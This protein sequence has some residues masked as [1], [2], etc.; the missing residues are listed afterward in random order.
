MKIRICKYN[1]HS[2]VAEIN[3]WDGIIESHGT[4]KSRAIK[5]LIKHIQANILTDK[6]IQ[7]KLNKI[8][9][10]SKKEIEENSKY[11]KRVLARV[12]RSKP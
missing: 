9:E 8:I 11:A 7:N 1:K 2:Y 10:I 12:K 4:T 6:Q 5:N 3:Y